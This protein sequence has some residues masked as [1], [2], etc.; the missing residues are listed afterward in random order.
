[1]V[2]IDFIAGKRKAEEESQKVS[3]VRPKKTRSSSSL[4][5]I[6][7]EEEGAQVGGSSYSEMIFFKDKASFDR[8]IKG[9]FAFQASASVTR[10]RWC[11]PWPP[12]P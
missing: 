3:E 12:P 8:F 10:C 4:V 5:S 2:F 9:Q 1:M 7:E 11:T 6:Q